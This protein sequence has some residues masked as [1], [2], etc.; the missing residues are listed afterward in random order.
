[1]NKKVTTL[2]AAI[3]IG[4]VFV[5]FMFVGCGD[6]GS[7]AHKKSAQKNSYKEVTA[8]LHQGGEFFMYASTE[9]TM[10]TVEK[11]AGKIRKLVEMNAADSPVGTDGVKIF[12]LLYGMF[13][14]SG[15][16]E[17][18]GLGFSS[19][20]IDAQKGLN[21]SRGVIH[22]Y[23]GQGKGL[24]WQLLG[25][26]PQP[27]AELDM[28]PADTVAAAF[29]DVKLH[30][31]WQWLKKEI[32][33][34]SMEKVKQGFAMAEP[35]LKKEGVDLEKILASMAGRIGIV[36]TLDSKQNTKIPMGKIALDIPEPAIA[37]VISVKDDT[38]FNLLQSKIPVP[39]K[40]DKKEIKIPVP[41]M[42]FPLEP[43]V[44][45]VEGKLIIATTPKI[46]AAMK[47]A[48]AKGNGLKTS[49]EFKAMQTD[50]P[51]KGNGFKFVGVRLSK[52]LIAVQKK[53]IE[54]VPEKEKK[55]FADIMEIFQMEHTLYSVMQNT[56]EGLM[57]YVNGNVDAGT[58]MLVPA[59]VPLGIVSAIAVPNFMTATHKGKQKAT[60]GDLKTIG[61]AIED[62]M[63][64]NYKA[65]EGKSL[66]DLQKKLQPFYIKTLPLKDAWGNDF[67]YTHGKGSKKDNY[68]IGSSCK[69]GIFNGWDQK[70]YYIVTSMDGFGNDIIFSNGMFV[71]GPKVK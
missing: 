21:H 29:S 46:I 53:V 54:M 47:D 67:V 70:G 71:Y 20:C 3:L 33:A 40:G 22:H 13:K 63:T 18:S 26:T 7:G 61:V 28:L 24:I 56:E 64:D 50:M 59:I 69:D 5:F 23:K 66:E 30:T 11:Y 43:I 2:W 27:L 41:P 39:Q 42:P 4:A 31:L 16:N 32:N 8:N 1:M 49:A 25:P 9:Q 44:V 58:L 6:S 52:A 15:I 17:I 37:I 48:K 38:I 55:G 57:M 65:P 12:D 34:S 14:R 45:Q 68:S 10:K 36:M 19:V 35:M 60:M 62:Y 51:Q